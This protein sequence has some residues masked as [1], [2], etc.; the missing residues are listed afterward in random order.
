M[1]KLSYLIKKEERKKRKREE[2]RK[3]REKERRKKERKKKE[4]N[5]LPQF[6][7]MS[8]QCYFKN[9]NWTHFCCR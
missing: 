1:S 6:N 8:K 2:K 4:A 3:K 7:D 5:V 9:K